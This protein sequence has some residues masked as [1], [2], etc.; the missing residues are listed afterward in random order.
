MKIA[1]LLL[2]LTLVL[3]NLSA[4]SAKEEVDFM[5][6]VF[7]MEKKAL[8]ADFVK[9]S[10][11]QKD[12]FWQL[13]DEYEMARKELGMKRIELLLKY[14]E[15]FDNLSNEIAADLLKEILALTN[16]ND[17]LVASYVKKVAKATDPVVAMQFHQIEMYVMSEIR[18]ALSEGLPFPEVKK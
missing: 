7:G 11:A 10:D 1:S 14:E 5:Q 15:N 8:V 18:L 4:Q 16:K 6:S 9:P 12:A 13:Y 3:S 17:K 2:L